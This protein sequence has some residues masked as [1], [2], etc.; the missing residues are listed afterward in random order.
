MKIGILA[1][2]TGVSRDTI[3]L[4]HKMGIVGNVTQ[5]Y[6][7][8]NY[9]EYGEEN[10]HRI[11]LVKQMKNIGLTLKECS[12]M[13]NALVDG[14]LSPKERVV[15]IQNKVREVTQKI[16]QLKQIKTFL[17]EHLNNDCAYT[18]DSLVGKLK[19]GEEK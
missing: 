7:Y 14:E 2:K 3:R 19:G 16:K 13:I 15:F 12:S 18:S 6:E 9:R 10:V 17:K 1:E 11:L 4:Y 8:N 5:P